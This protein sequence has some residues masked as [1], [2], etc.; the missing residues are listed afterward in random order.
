MSEICRREGIA[1]SAAYSLST[2]IVLIKFLKIFGNS[3]Y[4]KRVVLK[5][6]R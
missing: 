6:K 2:L 1:S 3:S 5:E 4:H